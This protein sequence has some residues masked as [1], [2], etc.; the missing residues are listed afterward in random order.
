MTVV[1]HCYLLPNLPKAMGVIFPKQFAR[2][3]GF[4]N[5]Q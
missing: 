2:G 5:N 3:K 4:Q 1:S